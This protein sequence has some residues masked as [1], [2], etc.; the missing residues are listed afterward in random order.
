[1]A[2]QVVKIGQVVTVGTTPDEIQIDETLIRLM[3]PAQTLT[4]RCGTNAG[5]IQFAI[6]AAPGGTAEAVATGVTTTIHNVQ[7]GF[8]NLWAVGSVAG[9][10]FTIY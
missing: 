3:Q 6:G 4:I 7:N 10:T 9:Q 5:T 1:M 8:R 2:L